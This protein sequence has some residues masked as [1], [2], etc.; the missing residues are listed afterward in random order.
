VDDRL[1]PS[2]PPWG[3][4]P[5][6]KAG[7]NLARGTQSVSIRTRNRYFRV[8]SWPRPPFM[9]KYRAMGIAARLEPG[10]SLE[11]CARVIELR[12]ATAG[13]QLRARF[14]SRCLR[15]PPAADGRRT[16]E[17]TRRVVHRRKR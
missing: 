5:G 7:S 13:D 17:R 14:G 3:F 16:A 8:L 9:R 1:T 4:D 15:V 11:F 10:E 6:R 2:R 12:R